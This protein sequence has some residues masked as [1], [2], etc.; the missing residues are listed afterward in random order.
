M[1]D[2]QDSQKIKLN[3]FPSKTN[4][5]CYFLASYSNI[6]KGVK[7]EGVE[8]EEEKKALLPQ[9]EISTRTYCY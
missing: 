1:K 3:I 8:E 7:Y 9:I 4:Q 6:N 2:I 5:H